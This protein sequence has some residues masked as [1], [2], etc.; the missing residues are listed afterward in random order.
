MA[1]PKINP[2]THEPD[3][4]RIAKVLFGKEPTIDD[5]TGQLVLQQPDNPIAVSFGS[6][7]TDHSKP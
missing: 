1:I 3:F 6:S 2:Y 4:K 7:R 5:D